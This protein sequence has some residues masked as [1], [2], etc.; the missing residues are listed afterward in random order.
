MA[1]RVNRYK[2]HLV[3]VQPE[4]PHAGPD[5]GFLAEAGVDHQPYGP[6]KPWLLFDIEKDPSEMYDCNG[7][8]SCLA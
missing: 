4:E 6:Q 3:T 7:F 8:R 1:V 5:K 2:A